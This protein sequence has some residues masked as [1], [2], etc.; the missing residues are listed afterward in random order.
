MNIKLLHRYSLEMRSSQKA[1]RADRAQLKC[2]SIQVTNGEAPTYDSIRGCM[3]DEKML[4][5]MNCYGS[6]ELGSIATSYFT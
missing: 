6:A 4:A 5:S 1:T 3:L 2:P